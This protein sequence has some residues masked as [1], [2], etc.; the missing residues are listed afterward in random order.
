MYTYLLIMVLYNHK[1]EIV[2]HNHII[3]APG[4]TICERSAPNL[5]PRGYKLLSA[6]CRV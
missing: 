4:I 2:Q 1:G 5:V 3:S 6:R